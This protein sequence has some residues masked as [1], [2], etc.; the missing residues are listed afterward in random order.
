MQDNR[1]MTLRAGLNASLRRLQP[2]DSSLS[3]W[4]LSGLI[5]DRMDVLLRCQPFVSQLRDKV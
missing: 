1:V 2:A 4:A 5:Q 3:L